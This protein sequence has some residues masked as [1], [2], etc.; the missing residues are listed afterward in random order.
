MLRF[1]QISFDTLALNKALLE[2]H[3]ARLRGVIL[4]KVEPAKYDM[5]SH[6]R[7][8]RMIVNMGEQI[9]CDLVNCMRQRRVEVSKVEQ[10]K[11][12]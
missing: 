7:P 3:G 1:L 5:V 6:V 9:R 11:Y 12:D 10:D 2:K 8:K 4:N